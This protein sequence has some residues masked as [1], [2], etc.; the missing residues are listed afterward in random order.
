MIRSAL[1]CTALV[2]AV[3]VSSGAQAGTQV[4]VADATPFLGDWTLTMQGPNGPGNF[5]LS[6]KVEKEKVVGEIITPG[7]APQAI[8]D[9]SKTDKYL[10]LNYS[11]NYEGNAV[12]AAVTLSPGADGK[13][14]AQIDFAGGAYVMSGSAAK[15]DKADKPKP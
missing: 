3:V 5:D 15:K 2:F 4:S 6:I 12:S 9:I 7:M 10:V 13:T 11:F 1:A 8:T 14:A